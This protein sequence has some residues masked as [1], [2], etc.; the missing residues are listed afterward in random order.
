MAYQKELWLTAEVIK[1]EVEDI[2]N[3]EPALAE[4]IKVNIEDGMRYVFC[5]SLDSELDGVVNSFTKS[6]L[7]VDLSDRL[8]CLEVPDFLS[9][10]YS[11]VIQNSSSH[12][13]TQV[14][15]RGFFVQTNQLYPYS[16]IP[17]DDAHAIFLYNSLSPKIKKVLDREDSPGFRLVFPK[18]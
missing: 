15:L 17:L 5:G 8:I 12:N 9:A 6:S 11:Y 7:K 3:N 2:L 10:A 18:K 16:A 14:F 1:K 4:R 13:L